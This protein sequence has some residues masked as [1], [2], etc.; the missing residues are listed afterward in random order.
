MTNF[1]YKF[2]SPNAWVNAAFDCANF[3]ERDHEL[4]NEFAKTIKQLRNDKT[5]IFQD[6]VTEVKAKELKGD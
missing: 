2:F 1:C 5:N 4:A 6:L 3:K